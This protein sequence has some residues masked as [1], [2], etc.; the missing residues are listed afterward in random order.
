MFLELL[1]NKNKINY[2]LI[3]DLAIGHYINDYH[4][5]VVK[6]N[7]NK[8][9]YWGTIVNPPADILDKYIFY[10]NRSDNRKDDII[11]MTNIINKLNTI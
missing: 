11:R 4:P 2:T 7:F 10:R 8:L 1:K 6:F 5:Q 3:D 9:F